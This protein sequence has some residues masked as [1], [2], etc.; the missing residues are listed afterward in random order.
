[1]AVMTELVALEQNGANVPPSYRRSWTRRR[2][3]SPR[4]AWRVAS[5]GWAMSHRTLSA[6]RAGNAVALADLRAK[7]VQWCSRSIAA[8]GV[9]TATWRCSCSSRRCPTSRRW[10]N[11]C[12]HRR[13]RPTTRSL[14]EKH[15]LAF[16]GC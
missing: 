7:P 10:G 12:R 11:T 9:R 8:P 15:G 14:A 1:M 5:C 16:P 13:R 3:T 6:R 2:M 4:P